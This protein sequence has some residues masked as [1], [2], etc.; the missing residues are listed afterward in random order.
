MKKVLRRLIP[1]LAL[2]LALT[3]AFALADVTFTGKV[4]PEEA[5]AV[6]APFGGNLEH[7]YLRVG[8]K[9]AQGDKVATISTTK[10]YATIEGT[11]AGVFG[12]VG[13]SAE[14]VI[15]RYGA[16]LYIE[17]TN[18]YVVTAST[19]KAYN[20]S[21][22]KLIHIGEKVFLSCTQDGS[23]RG[24]AVVTSVKEADESGNTA[25]TL[26]VTSGDFYMGET[27]GI[28][29]SA[30]YA[31]ET[32]IGRGTIAQNAAV[33]IS[34][35]GSLIRMHVQEGDF[36]ERGELLFETVDGVLD[37]LFA[38][39]NTILSDVSGVVA[40]VGAEA[41]AAASKDA[42]LITVYPDGAFEIEIEV[43]E[44]DLG[45]IHEGDPVVI[46]FD[47][48]A[49]A[50]KK[51]K[52]EVITIS[53]VNKS[54]EGGSA[55]YSAYIRFT[56]DEDVRLGMSVLVRVDNSESADADAADGASGEE[57]EGE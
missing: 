19:E 53:R 22:T 48:D 4:I 36:V 10:V 31:T 27:V 30:N 7:V 25:Y 42:S 28:Y 29:R 32:R 47:W 17:P 54:T 8:E 21:Q 5:V 14:N 20:S 38:V 2:V 23:H 34:A 9:V 18:R 12:Q 39:D 6:K 24:T 35:A 40:T 45:E 46:E 43:S 37:G 15:A 3:P 1:L 13:D 57:K 49:D 26:E 52:G 56:P 41:G 33:A 16:V 11:V 55:V 51:Y 44:Y 50:L